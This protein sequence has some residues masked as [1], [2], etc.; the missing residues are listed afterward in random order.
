MLELGN[1]RYFV[2]NLKRE[3][4]PQ[5]TIRYRSYTDGK[6][7]DKGQILSVRRERLTHIYY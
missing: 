6:E 7:V 3:E 1:D 4:G 2:N 5:G